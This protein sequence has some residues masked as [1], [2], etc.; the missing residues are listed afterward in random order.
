MIS[1]NR[2]Y[3][4]ALQ[5]IIKACEE[6]AQEE[7][8]QRKEEREKERGKEREEKGKERRKKEKKEKKRGKKLFDNKI[9]QKNEDFLH[10]GMLDR[11]NDQNRTDDFQYLS[12]PLPAITTQ[13]SSIQQVAL[14]PAF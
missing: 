3:F 7:R 8:H 9:L 1:K 6:T 13:I 14:T 5:F 2:E 12:E 4:T 10:P 11:R